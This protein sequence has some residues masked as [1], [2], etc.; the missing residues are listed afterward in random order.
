MKH[1]LASAVLLALAASAAQAGWWD[2]AGA[3]R[4]VKLADVRRDPARWVD[5]E[6][7]VEVRYVRAKDAESAGETRF[8]AKDWRAVEIVP[9]EVPA[10]KAKP[11]D[12]FA[13]AF[14]AKRSV[15][16]RRLEQAAAGARVELRACVRETS[17][18]EPWIEVL[19]VVGDGDPLTREETALLADADRLMAK[20]N[21]AAAET[22][23][24][25]LLDK[26]V[27]PRPLQAALWRRVGAACWSRKAM[28]QSAS[29]YAAAL[30][31]EPNDKA[32]AEKLAAAKAA[33]EADAARNPPAPSR[34]LL[35][36]SGMTPA[37]PQPV[38]SPPAPSGPS[39]PRRPS[40][41]VEAPTRPPAGKDKDKEETPPVPVEETPP[42][43][44]PPR[45]EPSGPK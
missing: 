32:T 6:V 40:K 15:G 35:P 37:A 44:P 18:G 38:P 36:P 45:S 24:R 1:P 20:D 16:E 26:R 7:L 29:A 9:A 5:V 30:A 25:A 39:E 41:K 22:Q 17:A 11:E 13:R 42:T 4:R 28:A 3:A 27:M 19:E 2:D 23:F 12:T 33:A 10:S 8:T 43:S 14:V 21:A 34:E 31:L